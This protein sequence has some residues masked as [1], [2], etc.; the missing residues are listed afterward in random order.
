MSGV[1]FLDIDGV[2]N[3]HD[4]NQEAESNTLRPECVAQF[5]RILRDVE[6]TVIITSAWRYMVFREAMTWIGFGYLLRTHGVSEKIS[7]LLGGTVW[8][9]EQVPTRGQ[10]IAR[11]VREHEEFQREF[12]QRHPRLDGQMPPPLCYAILD[13]APQGMDFRPVE[14]RLVRTDGKVGLTQADADRVIRMLQDK[15]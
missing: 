1:L 13:D 14:H 15:E 4:W 3:A 5:N 6:P 9:D 2:L 10:Q 7:A 8:P 12:C 11:W